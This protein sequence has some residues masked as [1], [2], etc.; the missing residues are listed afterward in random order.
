MNINSKRILDSPY[1]TH[2]SQTVLKM[3]EEGK[4]HRLKTKWWKEVDGGMTKRKCRGGNHK[5]QVRKKNPHKFHLSSNFKSSALIPKNSQVP[6][7]PLTV[8][9]LW[10]W[11]NWN[12]NWKL[13]HLR[14]LR[15]C[16]C[17]CFRRCRW[18]R[19]RKCWRCFCCVS[20][21]MSVSVHIRNRRI[22][23]ECQGFGY[24]RKGYKMNCFLIVQ[25]VMTFNVVDLFVGSPENGATVRT[26]F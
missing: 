10:K 9:L 3:Q 18:I 23:V 24:W 5:F 20:I 17:R 1:R 7:N 8:F 11:K 26:Q 4:L 2:V 21:G 13:F 14:K 6:K 12:E 25:F 19:N 15:C 22:S 16:S